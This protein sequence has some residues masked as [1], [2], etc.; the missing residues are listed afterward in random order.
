MPAPRHIM[1]GVAQKVDH[2]NPDGLV[3]MREFRRTVNYAYA[4][5]KEGMRR[6][7]FWWRLG[8]LGLTALVIGL[9]L[10]A[11]FDGNTDTEPWTDLITTYI[12]WEV[13][14]WVGGGFILWFAA[15]FGYRYWKRHRAS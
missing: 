15:H 9:E 10:V 5:G 8:F 1:R 14:V 3:D 11:A 4:E 13:F 12:P 6:S 7:R 2:T